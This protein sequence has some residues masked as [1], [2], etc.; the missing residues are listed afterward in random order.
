MASPGQWPVALGFSILNALVLAW[1]IR[2]ENA[3]LATRAGVEGRFEA[4]RCIGEIVAATVC[5]GL[6]GRQRHDILAP[7]AHV[8]DRDLPA[9]LGLLRDQPL[10]THLVADVVPL[11]DVLE[12]GFERLAAGGVGGKI[13]VEVAD[14]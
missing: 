2:G 11:V 8:C 6:V 3:A 1:R 5:V 9:A 10:A 7:V 14:G 12:R 4:D 13:V